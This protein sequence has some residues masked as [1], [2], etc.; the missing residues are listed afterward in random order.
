[1]EDF[2]KEYEIFFMI[3]KKFPNVVYKNFQNKPTT[4]KNH[5]WYNYRGS[6]PFQPFQPLIKKVFQLKILKCCCCYCSCCFW[7]YL[8]NTFSYVHW[9]R[10]QKF[11][12]WFLFCISFR[13]SVLQPLPAKPLNFGKF[14]TLQLMLAGQ[15]LEDFSFR[16]HRKK[17]YPQVVAIF[18]ANHNYL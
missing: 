9:I 15:D 1:M 4:P 14:V 3:F 11:Y 17:N 5:F 10:S 2:K 12:F 13:I 6:L 8:L 16:I 7:C 18:A